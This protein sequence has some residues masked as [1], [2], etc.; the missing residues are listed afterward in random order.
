MEKEG[1]VGMAVAGGVVL[2][3]GAIVGAGMALANKGKT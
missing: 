2:A 1:L 3:I